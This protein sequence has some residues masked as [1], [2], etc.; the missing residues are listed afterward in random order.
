MHPIDVVTSPGNAKSAPL[1]PPFHNGAILPKGYIMKR[2]VQVA[3]VALSCGAG[4]AWSQQGETQQSGQ[5]ADAPV[6]VAQAG[7]TSER[8]I[9]AREVDRSRELS[10]YEMSELAGQG[11]FPSR[12]GP[13][14]E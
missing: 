4:A 10:V 7:A 14:D 12:G 5:G 11:S 3:V 1:A 9:G 2:I 8:P 6:T 13:L